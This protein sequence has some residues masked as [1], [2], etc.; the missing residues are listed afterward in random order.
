[1]SNGEVSTG[2]GG[3]GRG[4]RI[5]SVVPHQGKCVVCYIKTVVAMYKCRKSL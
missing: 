3:F 2:G 4:K 1:M 5:V